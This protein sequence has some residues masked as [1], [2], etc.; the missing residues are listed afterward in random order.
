[1]TVWE[2]DQKYVLESLGDIKSSLQRLGDDIDD[3]KQR[4]TR[5]ETK[6]Q[7]ISASI[8]LAVSVVFTVI[9]KVL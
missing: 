6:Q 5:T 2:N 4:Q 1:M 3:L 9:T 7:Y 8:S